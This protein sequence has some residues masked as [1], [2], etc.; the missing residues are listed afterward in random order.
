MNRIPGTI[1]GLKVQQIECPKCH[2]KTISWYNPLY[3]CRKCRT[4]F[5]AEH[6][7]GYGAGKLIELI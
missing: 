1:A 5:Q 2:T 4:H 7:K 3:L 6:I